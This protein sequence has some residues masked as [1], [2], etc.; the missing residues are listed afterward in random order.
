[1]RRL[2]ACTVP[3][4]LI[5]LTTPARAQ[6]SLAGAAFRVSRATGSIHIDGDLND[7]G[8]RGA[9]RVT[10][11]YEVQ[12]GDNNEPPVKNVGYVTYDDRFLYVGFELDD[13][14]PSAIRAPLGDHDAISGNSTDFAGIFIDPLNTGR[15]ADEFFVTPGNVQYDAITDDASG[16]NSSPDFFWDSAAKITDRG[17]T[18]EIRIPFSSLRYRNVDPQT[19]G[20][21]LFRNYPRKFRYQ[22]FS[23]RVPKNNNCIICYENKM[24]G[25]EH[26]PQGGH[27][28]V[29]PY[30]S[31]T[32]ASHAQDD[33]AG[34]PLV[35]DGVK[36]RIGLDLKYT[37]NANN[38]LDL[39]VR[40]DFSQ[41]ESDTAQISA[42]ER[43]ALFYPE[44][45]PFFLEGV[46]LF[47]TPFQALYT[48]T[49]TAPDWGGRVT[50]KEGGIRY[51]ALVSDDEGGGT[52]IIPGPNSST[53]ADQ[54]GASTV[55]VGRAKKEVGLSFVGAMASDRE[56]KDGD[57]HNRVVGP[58]FQWRPSGRDVVTGQ[59]L[60]SETKTPDRVDLADEWTGQR[61]AGSAAQVYWNHNT[62]HLDWNAKY[63]DVGSGF[64][65]DVGFIPQVGYREAYAQTGW[66]TYPHGFWTRERTFL[67]VDYQTDQSGA[68]ITRDVEPGFGM[69]TRWSGFMQFRYIDNRARALD[70]LIERHQVAYYAQFS[71]SRRVAL[72]M[73]NGTLGQDIDFDNGRPAR[74]YTLNSELTLQASD[75]LNID[76]I[77]NVRSLNEDVALRPDAHLF[78]QQVSRAKG[79]YMFTS[80]LFLR[81]IAQYVATRR[82]PGLFIDSVD[83][84]SGDFGGSALLAYKINW[85]SV[86]FMGYSDDRELP[87]DQPTL[88]P[89][90]RQ[91]FV[92]ISYAFQR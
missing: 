80:R 41:V 82:D 34:E 3:I 57:W 26:L 56:S 44:K 74:G 81:V 2:C 72:L 25:L 71:P 17:W 21:I 75:H 64:R 46:D 89:L 73:I 42:N 60:Y 88:Q 32:D 79:T 35:H 8:W 13:P 20:I 23:A 36:P 50:G 43:F 27:L 51:T 53:M 31:G 11:W 68:V 33:T 40:P 69:D 16:E 65:S 78:T 66:Q 45:R 22:F 1:M 49:I 29:A 84:R 70:Q 9:T 48:R 12:P 52:V 59:W 63:V 87:T 7:E 39:T 37:P 38:A 67:T 85:Q 58:D 10:T 4:L 24:L 5:G 28:V 19:W 54:A 90:D 30:V 77:E 6:S 76:L 92:K 83:A 62:R 55:F 47:Q 61:L 18:L 91:F 14:S 86:L 15:T